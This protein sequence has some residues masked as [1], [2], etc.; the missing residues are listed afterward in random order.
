VEGAMGPQLPSASLIDPIQRA[1]HSATRDERGPNVAAAQGAKIASCSLV[2][3]C[4]S[5]ALP[6]WPARVHFLSHP[7][8]PFAP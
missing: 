1:Q 8:A 6:R 3:V 4:R 2:L 7:P 5:L